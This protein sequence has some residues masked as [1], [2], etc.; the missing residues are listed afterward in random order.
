MAKNSNKPPEYQVICQGNVV[1]VTM[2]KTAAGLVAD[3]LN[4]VNPENP[5]MEDLARAMAIEF[6]NAVQN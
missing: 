4:I 5:K 3:A 6:Q 1:I 2:T